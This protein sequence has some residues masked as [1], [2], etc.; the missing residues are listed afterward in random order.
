[1]CEQL[2]SEPD[3]DKLPPTLDNLPEDVQNAFTIFS[4]MPDRW[5]GMS[6]SY[7]G[8]DWSS[9]DFFL[10]LFKIE[11]RKTVVFFISKIQNF[12]V[13]KLNE[14]M[15]QKRKT[16]ERKSRSGGKQYAHNVQG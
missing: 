14:E 2:G 11:D 16:E 6:G 10:D 8:K 5:D 4:Y 13:E 12:Q 3:P 15:R 7:F 9:I 1:M